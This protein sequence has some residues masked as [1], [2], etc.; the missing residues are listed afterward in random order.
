[1]DTGQGHPLQPFV[2]VLVVIAGIFDSE[3]GQQL[4]RCEVHR[5]GDFTYLIA[6]LLQQFVER[7][8]LVEIG[9]SGQ[10]V[11]RR[12]QDRRL[13]VNRLPVQLPTEVDD[14]FARFG[15]PMFGRSE[16]SERI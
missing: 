10:P 8:V 4:R 15:A 2:N 7:Q 6:P 13:G 11:L 16:K 12:R 3:Y 1:M 14:L 9:G 5:V